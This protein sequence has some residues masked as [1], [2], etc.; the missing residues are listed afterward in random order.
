[1]DLEALKTTLASVATLRPSGRVVAVTGLALRFTLPGVRV[2]D[3]VHVKRRG[4]PLACEVVGFAQGEAVAMALGALSGVGPDDEVETTGEPLRVR[5][6]DR[7]LGRVVDGLG[8]P[9]DGGAPITDGA[10]VPV[11]RDP[12]GPLERRLVTRPLATGVRVLDGLLTL[13]EGQ[14]IGLF[15]GSGVG[16][17]TLLGAIARGVDADAVVVALSLIHI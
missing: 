5:A 12:P 4:G 15:A 3:V 17:S 11:D 10:L 2:G 16:K 7:L 13:G 6:S 8:R 9:I 14:R 1:M